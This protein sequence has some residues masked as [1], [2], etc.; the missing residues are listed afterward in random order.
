MKDA[1]GARFSQNDLTTPE[2]KQVPTPLKTS[3]SKEGG[4]AFLSALLRGGK[5]VSFSKKKKD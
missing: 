3:T 1:Y 2:E 5:G 4:I